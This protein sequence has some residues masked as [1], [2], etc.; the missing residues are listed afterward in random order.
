MNNPPAVVIDE[1]SQAKLLRAVY[2]NRQLEE[3]MT[4]FWLNHFNVFAGKGP[5]RLLLTTDR[6]PPFS[7]S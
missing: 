3:V 5:E 7:L 2:S 1:L 4:D 6:Y